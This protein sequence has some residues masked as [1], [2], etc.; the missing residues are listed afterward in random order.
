MV[1]ISL[2]T[3]PV[4]LEMLGALTWKTLNKPRFRESN[5]SA[6][7]VVSANMDMDEARVKGI[8]R[9]F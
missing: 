2:F 6:E 1:V 9:L 5:R 3:R 4:P 8:Q 7:Y